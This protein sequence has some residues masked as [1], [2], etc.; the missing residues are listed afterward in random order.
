MSRPDRVTVRRAKDGGYYWRRCAPNGEE[1]SRSSETYVHRYH[2]L[3][4]ALTC[5]PGCQIDVDYGGTDNT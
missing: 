5:N 3:D 4:Q 1:L 2:A